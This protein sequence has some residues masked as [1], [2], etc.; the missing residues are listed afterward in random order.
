M[1]ETTATVFHDFRRKQLVQRLHRM[2]LNGVVLIFVREHFH[3]NRG[4]SLLAAVR[5]PP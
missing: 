2:E 1:E 4:K 5:Q 3:E